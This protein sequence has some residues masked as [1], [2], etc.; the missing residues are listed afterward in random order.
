MTGANANPQINPAN[1][2]STVRNAEVERQIINILFRGM[3]YLR[4]HL[5]SLLSVIQA[6]QREPEQREAIYVEGAT[7]FTVDD[8]GDSWGVRVGDPNT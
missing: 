4:S 2:S 5:N 6:A 8:G 7:G 3:N 1:F